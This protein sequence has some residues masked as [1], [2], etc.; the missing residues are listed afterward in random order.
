MSTFSIGVNAYEANVANRVGSN[1]F[2]YRLLCELEKQT[3]VTQT[4]G[5]PVVP[6][7]VEWAIYLP[8]PPLSDMP[9]EREGWKYVV[10]GPQ[11]LWTQWRLPLALFFSSRHHNVFVSLGH[12]A[13]RLSPFPSV[14]CIL[15]LAFLKL[16]QFFRPQD[17]YKLRSWTRYSVKHASHVFTISRYSK[18]DILTEYKVD[19][20]L[21]TV[22]YPGVD[23][24]EEPVAEP[25]AE[26][27]AQKEKEVLD[28]YGLKAEQYMVSIGTIQP[29]KNMINAIKAFEILCQTEMRQGTNISGRKLVFIGKSGWM[30]GDFDTALAA[31]PQKDKIIITGY[32]DEV[33]KYILL[34]NAGASILVGFYEGFGIPAIESLRSGVVPIVANAASLPEVVGEFGVLVDPYSPNDIA[35]GLLDTLTDLPGPDKKRKMYEWAGQ[36]SWVTS[37]T[38]MLEVLRTKFEKK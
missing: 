10:C 8:S 2:A 11:A 20:A 5:S 7:S 1:M 6:V 38:K 21:V 14:V 27:T 4:P 3:R 9:P 25:N 31:S 19:D 22:I 18:T 35:R 37:A 32:V 13:P 24:Q 15:D 36:F 28:Q 17:L 33:T 34:R 23:G 29:R 12:F 30:T 26:L 16:P